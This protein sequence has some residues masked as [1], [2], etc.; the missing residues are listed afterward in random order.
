VPAAVLERDVTQPYTLNDEL[1]DV[2]A[3]VYEHN[4]EFWDVYEACENSST[5]R[6]TSSS[7]ASATCAPCSA[8]S[9]W[10]PAPAGRAARSS[11][12][13]RLS[14]TFFPELFEVRTRI[15]AL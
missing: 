6:T 13:A 11:S 2:F 12:S 5:W 3:R 9:A 8:R 7:G 15:A 14:I 4:D 1:V 10:G